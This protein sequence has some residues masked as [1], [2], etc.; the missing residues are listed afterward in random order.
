[1]GTDRVAELENQI[2]ELKKQLIIEKVKQAVAE[3]SGLWEYDVAGLYEREAATKMIE[4]KLF[5]APDEPGALL[6]VD[7]ND[8]KVINDT[9]G[10]VYGD[11][12]LEAASNIISTS[13]RMKD[14]VGRIAGD[15]FFIFC[16][17]IENETAAEKLVNK[18]LL[19]FQ[20]FMEE[21]IALLKMPEDLLTRSVNV[22]FSGG[23]KKRNDI[24]QM[25]VLEPELC[26][27][28]ESDSGLDID[29][30]KVVADGVN[31]LRDGKRSFIIVTHYQRILDYIKPDYVHV[32]YQG[33]IVKSGDFTLVKQLEEQ[34]YGWLTEQ[35]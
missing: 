31:S 5:E 10:R 24:L 35:Q 6:L 22:G 11:T 32:L 26:I 28:D 15:A 2:S 27:L 23:E 17:G 1:M 18:I 30:L 29:A 8:F 25:A 7:L 3:D 13:F 4:K 9:Y 16:S 20:D 21:K 34:G 19:R 33:R 14:I 12:V